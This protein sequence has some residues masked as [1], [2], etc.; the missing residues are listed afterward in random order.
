MGSAWGE[1]ASPC[2]HL[3]QSSCHTSRT[4][5]NEW[6]ALSRTKG[7][8]SMCERRPTRS[9]PRRT[10]SSC[11]N[12]SRCRQRDRDAGQH[13]TPGVGHHRADPQYARRGAPK[14]QSWRLHSSTC[15]RTKTVRGWEDNRGAERSTTSD[16]AVPRHCTC[17]F[18]YREY[19][20][21]ALPAEPDGPSCQSIARYHL[22]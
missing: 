15:P 4:R 12:A 14:R 2:R 16:R 21:A 20:R 7:C 10:L 13:L 18:K 11:P 17:S 6:L 9:S 5:D 3:Q 22:R 19:S 8:R 1:A